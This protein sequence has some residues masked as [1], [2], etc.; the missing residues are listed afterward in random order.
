MTITET[1]TESP[2][3]PSPSMPA[4]AS[5]TASSTASTT[6]DAAATNTAATAAAAAAAA[7][8]PSAA[9]AASSGAPAGAAVDEADEVAEAAEA[10]EART[11]YSPEMAGS[12]ATPLSKSRYDSVSGYIYHCAANPSMVDRYNDVERA[13]DVWSL[14]TLLAHGVDHVLAEHIAHLFVRDPLV[15]FEG[16]VTEV[17]DEKE[18]DHFENIQSTNW[19]TVRWKP[20]PPSTNPLATTAAAATDGAASGS[21]SG[22]EGGGSSPSGTSSP[23]HIGWRTEFRPMEVQLT[24]F[25]NAVRLPTSTIFDDWTVELVSGPFIHSFIP[26]LP[27]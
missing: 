24:D 7:N 6:A 19:Q 23:P 8:S 20:P 16:K 22:E 26:V 4:T 2:Q 13:L 12:G 14:E 21:G 11:Y 25:E 5:S 17:D 18:T 1:L 15:I 9:A 10:R 3:T 27:P